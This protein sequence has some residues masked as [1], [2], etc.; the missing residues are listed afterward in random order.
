MARQDANEAF[1]ATS[2]LYGANAPYL[3]EIQDRYRRDPKSVDAEWRDFFEGLKDAP[4]TDAKP[5]WERSDWPPIM[6]G[7][8][9]SALTIHAHKFSKS[10]VEKIEKAGGK[11]VVLGGEAPVAAKGKL[12]SKASR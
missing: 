12:V 6:N 8:L 3:E 9:T 4:E 11:A 1:A 10:A 5:S 7:E 2:F